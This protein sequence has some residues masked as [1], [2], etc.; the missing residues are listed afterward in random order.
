[1]KTEKEIRARL[2]ELLFL[3]K[4]GKED[5][6]SLDEGEQAEMYTLQWVLDEND[7]W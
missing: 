6:F 4:A 2:A 5:D 7:D 1:M 3:E